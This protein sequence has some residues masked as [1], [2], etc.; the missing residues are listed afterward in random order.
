MKYQ[1]NLKNNYPK[2]SFVNLSKKKHLYHTLSN[3]YELLIDK[4]TKAEINFL[5]D[6][7]SSEANELSKILDL[8]CGTGRHDRT[9]AQSG[10]QITG[11]DISSNM[12][13]FAKNVESSVNFE[14]SD[15]RYY[16]AIEKFD[17]AICM[18][19]TFSYLSTKSDV[20]AFLN[21]ISHNLNKNGLLIL[22]LKNHN[23]CKYPMF[24]Y[25]KVENNIIS[26]IITVFKNRNKNIQYGQKVYNLLFIDKNQLEVF[27]DEE[28]SRI[29][30][31]NDIRSIFSRNFKIE[32]IYGDYNILKPYNKNKSERLIIV[33]KK[34]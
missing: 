9:L 17:A 28:L 27:I 32:N 4:D 33:M 30:T 14:I 16:N 24:Y 34:K 29:Y 10:F 22:D 8:G 7:F 1:L 5:L 11:V 12:I 31:V 6:I 19:S 23:S 25:R 13:N 18:W 15:M 2:E 26:G 3:I 21:M 20:Q